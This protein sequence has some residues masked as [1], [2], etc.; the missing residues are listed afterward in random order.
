[1]R[2]LGACVGRPSGGGEA[3][4]AAERAHGPGAG[5]FRAGWPLAGRA[6]VPGL[7]PTRALRKIARPMRH[8][9]TVSALAAA[10]AL[11]GCGHSDA[12]LGT[13]APAKPAAAK[14]APQ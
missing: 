8:F 2:R 6:G 9:M 10:L 4:A 3:F 11:G 1:E 13:Q 5:P 7:R 12:L 14:P